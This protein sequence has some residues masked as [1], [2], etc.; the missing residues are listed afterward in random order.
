LMTGSVIAFTTIAAV[1]MKDDL[2]GG[3]SIS[4][5]IIILSSR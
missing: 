1:A 2:P 4:D 3:Q 5:N